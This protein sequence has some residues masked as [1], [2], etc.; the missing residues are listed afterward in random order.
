[1]ALG[2][3]SMQYMM[4]SSSIAKRRKATSAFNNEAYNVPE[5]TWAV[6]P[7]GLARIAESWADWMC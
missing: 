4:T 7:R 6:T 1:L 5:R 2:G 3:S